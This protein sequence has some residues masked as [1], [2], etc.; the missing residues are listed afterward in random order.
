MKGLVLACLVVACS[1]SDGGGSG[2]HLT[3]VSPS[4]GPADTTITISGTDLCDGLSGSACGSAGTQ[5]LLL[6]PQQVL[7]P[8]ETITDTSIQAVIPP[9]ATTPGSAQLV[10]E[11]PDG[12]SSNGLGFTI[13]LQ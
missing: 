6:T 12:T 3:T 5:V 9:T 10:V 1:N 7:V 13:T 4:S 8:V 11:A 2:P